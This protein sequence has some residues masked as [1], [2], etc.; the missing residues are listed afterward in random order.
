MI[1]TTWLLVVPI[2]LVLLGFINRSFAKK[3][4]YFRVDKSGPMLELC[5]VGKSFNAGDILAFTELRRW[6]CHDHV[7][8]KATRQTGVLI[9]TQDGQI[10]LYPVFRELEENISLLGCR[11]SLAD[12]LAQVFRASVRRV[13]LDRRES[14]ALGDF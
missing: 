3:G 5:Q 13:T 7:P 11:L 4:D 8:W 14:Q 12:R 9:Q 6:C 1:G 2:L 10:E